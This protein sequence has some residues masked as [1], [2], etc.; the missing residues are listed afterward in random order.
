MLHTYKCVCVMYMLCICYVYAMCML[1]ICYVYARHDWI[2]ADPEQN[3][4][5]P[6]EPPARG[7]HQAAELRE[8]PAATCCIVANHDSTGISSK[9]AEKHTCQNSPS[10]VPTF[11]H[12]RIRINRYSQH[13]LFLVLTSPVVQAA[14]ALSVEAVLPHQSQI[15]TAA[16]LSATFSNIQQPVLLDFSSFKSPMAT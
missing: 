9:N 7:R 15:V 2:I 16:T 14:S 13:A 3:G 10:H 6:S 1:C 4:S 11:H 12:A 5:C 8:T